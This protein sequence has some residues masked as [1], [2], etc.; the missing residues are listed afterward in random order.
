MR[1]IDLFDRVEIGIVEVIVV[2]LQM[3]KRVKEDSVKYD[4]ATRSRRIGRDISVR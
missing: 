1:P 2:H 4:F 3:G